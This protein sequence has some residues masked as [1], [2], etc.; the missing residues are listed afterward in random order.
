MG[1]T[2]GNECDLLPC[3]GCPKPRLGHRT[4]ELPPRCEIP[5]SITWS[6]MAS[7]VGGTV[8]PSV[9]AVCRLMTGATRLRFQTLADANNPYGHHKAE[10]AFP[11]TVQIMA[12]PAGAR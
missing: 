2:N 5:Y 12:V 7:S 8:M 4:T 1:R 3:N 10:T 11:A 6:A 9:R